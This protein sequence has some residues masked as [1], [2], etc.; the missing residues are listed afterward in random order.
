MLAMRPYRSAGKM[1]HTILSC[2][3]YTNV[4][5]SKLKKEVYFTLYLLHVLSVAKHTEDAV[6][7]QIG[8]QSTW[9]IPVITPHL[10]HT[11]PYNLQKRTALYPPWYTTDNQ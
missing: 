7:E 4:P 1:K 6:N 2:A 10:N 3:S 5:D 11:Y 9:V 8:V